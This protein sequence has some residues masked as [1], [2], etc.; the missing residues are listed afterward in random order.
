M[1]TLRG[2]WKSI[3]PPSRRKCAE[4]SSATRRWNSTVWAGTNMDLGIKNKV[5]L[6]TGGAKGIGAAIAR[7]AT[8][9]GAMVA[10]VDRDEAAAKR[11]SVELASAGTRVGY[12][13]LDLCDVANC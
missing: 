2:Y 10:I 3:C 11:L 9:E 5:A 13:V 4:K 12:I 8:A 7:G 6:V 1:E